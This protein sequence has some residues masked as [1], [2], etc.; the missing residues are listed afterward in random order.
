M[1]NPVTQHSAFHIR[2]G[3]L[4]KKLWEK[5]KM[6]VTVI[7]CSTARLRVIRENSKDR[8][9]HECVK[10]NFMATYLCEINSRLN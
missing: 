1:A 7:G 8:K 6:L 10:N 2:R 5:E 9:R 3:K 4:L